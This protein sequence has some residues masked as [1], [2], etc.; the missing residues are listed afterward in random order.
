MCS[1]RTHN[2]NIAD[3]P[4]QSQRDLV[5]PLSKTGG[6]GGASGMGAETQNP[7][8]A[9]QLPT[10]DTD[11]PASPGGL[12]AERPDPAATAAVQRNLEVDIGAARAIQFDAGAT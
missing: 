4:D 5:N 1:Q 3:E 11:D 10:F 6:S 8:A 9:S 7:I 12:E 2:L